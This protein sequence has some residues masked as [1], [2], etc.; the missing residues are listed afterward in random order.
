[1]DAVD[2]WDELLADMSR[3]HGV[4]FCAV[5][6]RAGNRR[7]IVHGLSSTVFSEEMLAKSKLFKV[8]VERGMPTVI[9]DVSSVEYLQDDCL[10]VGSPQV[11]F[12]VEVPFR[13]PG[14]AIAGA[15]VL[16]DNKPCLDH[17]VMDNLDLWDQWASRAESIFAAG[18]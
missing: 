3:H 18:H 12:Y 17:M 1:M 14:G 15:L 8:L 7:W 10:V 2:A 13:S 5:S 16:A 9:P 11:R 4:D 6:C